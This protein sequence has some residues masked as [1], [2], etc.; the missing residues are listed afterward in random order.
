[1]IHIRKTERPEIVIFGEQ[2]SFQTPFALSAGKIILIK[3][4][5]S[6]VKV[7]RFSPTEDDTYIYTSTRIRDIVDATVKLGGSYT[8]IVGA[9]QQ[10]KDESSFAGRVMF[11]ALPRPGRQ[12]RRDDDVQEDPATDLPALD[13][14]N[15]TDL[16]LTNVS[17]SEHGNSELLAQPI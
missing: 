2:E 3:G 6:K 11:D 12:Y 8:D 4:T 9:I 15:E 14:D 17:P 16:E 5:G 7:T 1:M 13:D 10:A